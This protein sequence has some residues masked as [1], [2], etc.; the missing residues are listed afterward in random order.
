MDHIIEVLRQFSYT[1]SESKVYIALLQ[2]GPKTGYEA[3]KISGVPRSK[4]Y[5]VLESLTSRGVVATTSGE[6]TI[7]YRAEP[8]ERL[9]NLIQN[10]V[11]QGIDEL[12]HESKRLAFSVDDEQIWKLVDYNSIIDKCSSIIRTAKNELMVQIWADELP[13]VEKLL[14]E[15]EK[16]LK[17][18]IILYDSKDKYDTCLT[19]VY[20]H[21]F[22]QDRMRETGYRWI[23]IAADNEQMIHAA[24]PSVGSAEAIYTRNMNVVYFSEEYIRHDAYCLRI[25]NSMPEAMRKQFGENM[26]GI[27][28]V[29]DIK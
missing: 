2:N 19:Q 29:F 8:I 3:S 13:Y 16:K 12:R 21:G 10:N 24:I 15:T 22:E 17:Q 20:K 23:T 25:I 7:L 26:E 11:Q 9:C 28:D 18:L 4:V 6:K 27:R 5:N 14:K 1:E